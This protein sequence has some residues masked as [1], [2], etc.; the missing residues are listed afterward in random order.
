VSFGI[1]VNVLLYASDRGSPLHPRAVAFLE[2]CVGGNE[3]FCLAW[4]T[5]MSYLRMATHPS[6]FAKPLSHDDAAN[7]VEALLA[8]PHMRVIGEEENFWS[9]Y[10]RVASEVPIR[11]NLVPDAHLATVMRQHGVRTLYTH[12]RDF[13][14]FS[15]LEVRDP[16]M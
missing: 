9:A 14:K 5:L 7:N 2:Q 12:D 11:G 15:F 6:I 8:V 1:D 16:L 4:V 13:R 10:R 3:L